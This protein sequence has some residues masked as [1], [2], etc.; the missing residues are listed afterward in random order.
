MPGLPLRSRSSAGSLFFFL[1]S[2][3]LFAFFDRF[4]FLDSPCIT[5][6]GVFFY[7]LLLILC[8]WDVLSGCSFPIL[9][10]GIGLFSSEEF[11]GIAGLFVHRSGHDSG[12]FH[13][14]RLGRR[15]SL[16]G[17]REWELLTQ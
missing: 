3:L 10:L 12:Y 11:S 15:G 6:F 8:F 17:G 9:V 7:R 2:W 5:S 13:G 1:S 14:T 16:M 4:L